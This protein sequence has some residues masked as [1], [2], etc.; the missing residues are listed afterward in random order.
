MQKV[1]FTFHSCL[2]RGRLWVSVKRHDMNTTEVNVQK[3]CEV[4]ARNTLGEHW[5]EYGNE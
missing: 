4:G 3:H 5:D 1:N 2:L